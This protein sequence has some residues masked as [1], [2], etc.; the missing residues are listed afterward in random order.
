M[1]FRELPF[2]FG[3]IAAVSKCSISVMLSEPQPRSGE[4][5]RSTLRFVA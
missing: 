4:A 2:M 5:S 3:S 1:T